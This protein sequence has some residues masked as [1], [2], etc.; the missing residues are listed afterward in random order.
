VVIYTLIPNDNSQ[1]EVVGL[2][3]CDSSP[4]SRLRQV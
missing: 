4:A 1:F 3:R 2:F